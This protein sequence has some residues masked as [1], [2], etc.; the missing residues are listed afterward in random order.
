MIKK[1]KII[2]FK[3]FRELTI[4]CNMK[5]NI[6]IG[7][8]GVGKTSILQAINMVLSGSYSYVEKIG[9]KSIFNVEIIKESIERFRQDSNPNV[10]PE[11]IV[12]L[13]FEEEFFANQF[14]LNGNVNTDKTNESG[15]QMKISPD[16]DSFKLI[17]NSILGNGIFPFEYYKLEFNTFAGK[18][19][20]TYKKIHKFRQEFIDTSLINTKYEIKKHISNA[21]KRSVKEENRKKINNEFRSS[22]QEFM[23]KMRQENII[24][25]EEDFII[26]IDLKTED[27]FK[28]KI[29]VI[30][31]GIDISSIGHGEKVILSISN[32]IEDYDESAKVIMIE[33]PENHLS[34][35]NMLKL[36]KL[37]EKTGCQVFISTHS[38]MISTRLGLDEC[39][40]IGENSSVEFN[41]LEKDTV[42]FFKKSSNENVLNFILSKRVILV[43]GNAE[44]ILM[45]KFF[46]LKSRE[47]DFEKDVY[48]CS[49]G[50]LTFKRYLNI[51][52]K[53]NKKVAVITDNDQDI[54]T[55]IIEKYKEFEKNENIKICNDLDENLYTFEVCLYENNKKWFKVN[56]VT[57]SRKV[58]EYMLKN[59]TESAYR[60]LEKLE[61]NDNFVI[62][63][64]IEEAIEWIIK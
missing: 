1:I 64:Y 30:K 37:L 33:E 3:K 23:N 20:N 25:N 27:G 63:K 10:L 9:F 21:Y 18:S 34:F 54:Q 41:S 62:P 8:N 58:L 49:V 43:E 56:K 51:A 32:I 36:I 16:I 29:T 31:E 4:N 2:N 47:F 59:K 35:L 46:E 26:D 11:L 39:I 22:A 15:L 5:K 40:L 6:F 55:N 45:S 57:S 44:Y 48:I 24:E 50:G 14:D 28:D 17:K 52:Y 13:Y 12:E 19:Y 60:I 42:K 53:L 38:N 61:E 7:E